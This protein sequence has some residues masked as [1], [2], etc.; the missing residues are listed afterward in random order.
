[1]HLSDNMFVANLKQLSVKNQPLVLKLQMATKSSIT[2]VSLLKPQV[3]KTTE[4][5]IFY[6][7]IDVDRKYLCSFLD[8]DKNLSVYAFCKVGPSLRALFESEELKELLQN[9]RFFLLERPANEWEFIAFARK[10]FLKRFEILIEMKSSL[11]KA[12][13]EELTTCLEQTLLCFSDFRDFGKSVLT[14]VLQN[15]K[16]LQKNFCASSL[17]GAFKDVPA[18][19]CGAGSSLDVQKSCI[20]GLQNKALIFV[21]GSSIASFTKESLPFHIAGAIDPN[22]PKERFSSIAALEKPFFY[23]LRSDPFVKNLFCKE[24]FLSPPSDGYPLEEHIYKIFAEESFLE[25]TGFT[26]GNYLGALAASLGCNPVVLVGMDGGALEGKE[27]ASGVIDTGV[28]DTSIIDDKCQRNPIAKKSIKGNALF[29]RKD[30]LAS[31]D[32][33][34]KLPKA[35]PNT[36]FINATFDGL[37]IEG[38][39]H[40]ALS[41]AFE[42]EIE[43]DIEGMLQ[44]ALATGKSKSFNGELFRKRLSKSM[45]QTRLYVEKILHEIGKEDQ[46]NHGLLA[47]YEIELEEEIAHLKI[48]HPVYEVFKYAIESQDSREEYLHKMLFYK[49]C[50]KSIES[51]F[52]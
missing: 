50:Q 43:L 1:M 37:E 48:L 47:L 19:I 36:K 7:I 11:E 31:H 27:Y 10:V 51:I 28:L 6:D 30:L 14:N 9:E 20:E 4:A 52:C 15:A 41:D 33:F 18:L 49:R 42:K 44:C 22:V 24:K 16:T 12:F 39:D 2:S 8:R 40:K 26:V 13:K 3:K 5:A 25:D 21:G 38:M 34:A 32:Y 46:A 29:T 45:E 17:Y 23:K 35:F